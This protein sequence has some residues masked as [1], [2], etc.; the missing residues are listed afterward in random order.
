MRPWHASD[1]YIPK[2]ARRLRDGTYL[3]LSETLCEPVS[4]C[5]SSRYLREQHG[6]GVEDNAGAIIHDAVVE[7][8]TRLDGASSDADLEDLRTRADRIYQ[9]HGHV[10]MAQLSRG[11]L[12]RYRDIHRLSVALSRLHP[13]FRHHCVA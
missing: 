8:F 2:L 4:Y 10:G 11:F 12:R 13:P 1:I 6:L 5:H 7:M 9:S 3:T